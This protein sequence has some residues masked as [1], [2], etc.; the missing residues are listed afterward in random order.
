MVPSFGAESGHKEGTKFQPGKAPGRGPAV[1]G[2]RA[3]Q[4]ARVA[5]SGPGWPLGASGPATA[6]RGATGRATPAIMAGRQSPSNRRPAGPGSGRPIFLPPMNLD[7]LVRELVREVLRDEI[8]P[9][10]EELRAV[11]EAIK[12]GRKAWMRAAATSSQSRRSRLN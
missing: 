5:P 10:R 7:N 4:R 6:P 3:R 1:A 11:A 8:E 12:D 2:T 9:L